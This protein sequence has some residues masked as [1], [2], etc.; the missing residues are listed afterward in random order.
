MVVE[1]MVLGSTIL[2]FGRKAQQHGGVN[3][4]MLGGNDDTFRIQFGKHPL[5]LFKPIAFNLVE[6]I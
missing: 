6:F 2:L 5:Y 4:T 3:I 1:K